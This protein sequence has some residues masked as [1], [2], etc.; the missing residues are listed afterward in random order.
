MIASLQPLLIGAVLLWAATVKLLGRHAADA[1]RRSALVPLVGDG[2]VTA[3]RMVGVAE[4]LLG[5]ALIAPPALPAETVGAAAAQV[6]FLLFLGYARW[7][8]PE[9][10]CGCLSARRVPVRWRSFAR[11]GGLLVAALVATGDPWSTVTSHPLASVA[12]LLGEAALVV[13]LSAELDVF[14]LE[15]LRRIK[16]ALTH[17]LPSGSF[18]VPI[19]S[20]VEQL[21]RSGAYRQAA[22]LL[23]S[24]VRDWWDEDE[25][26]MV[27]YSGSHEGRAATAVFAVP[28]LRYDPG[29][30]RMAMVA[31]DSDRILLALDPAADP[32][33][34]AGWPAPEP[35]P[36]A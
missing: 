3:Y 11:A 25:W 23:R 12:V 16:V 6:G 1:A 36:V 21:H 8:A 35:E 24:D 17:P 19:G 33:A 32:V 29:A 28:R 10:S 5:L 31:E 15:P 18:D 7:K 4:A 9:S 34:E 2:A 27:C 20:T 30:V 22:P 26:R 13:V 14:W